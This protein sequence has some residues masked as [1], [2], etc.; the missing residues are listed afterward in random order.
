MP[1]IWV[2]AAGNAAMASHFQPVAILPTAWISHTG[3][4]WNPKEGNLQCGVG[5]DYVLIMIM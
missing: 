2:S 5:N 4:S 3:W 1:D